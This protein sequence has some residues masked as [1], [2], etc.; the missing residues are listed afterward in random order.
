MAE[1]QRKVDGLLAQ[2][3]SATDEATRLKLQKQLEAERAATEAIRSKG[4]GGPAPKAGGGSGAPKAKCTPGDPLC[5]D[6]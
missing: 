1:Q 5:S 4:G 6:L 3:S 2:L